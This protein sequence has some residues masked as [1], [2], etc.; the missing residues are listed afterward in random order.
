MDF[1]DFDNQEDVRKY[2]Y[3]ITNN[4][5]SFTVSS[6][7][8]WSNPENVEHMKS[9]PFYQLMPDEIDDRFFN[10]YCNLR[11]NNQFFKTKEMCVLYFVKYWF[12]WIRKGRPD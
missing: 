4:Y 12:E 9:E 7:R 5:Y 11:P 2:L 3:S 1:E 10:W 6:D 8:I